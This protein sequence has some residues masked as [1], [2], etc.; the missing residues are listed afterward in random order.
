MLKEFTLHQL[1]V[2]ESVVRHGNFTRAAEE[3]MLT[4][5]TVSLQVKQ[6]TRAVGLP[7]FEQLGKRLYLTDAGQAVYET[8]QNLSEQ[9]GD[10]EI[11]LSEIKGVAQGRLRLAMPTAIKAFVPRML[12]SFL[13]SFPGVDISV[14]LTNYRY[15]IERLSH[16]EDD[17]YIMSQPPL[18]LPVKTLPLFDNP[19]VVVAPSQHPLA[20]QQHIPLSR[21]NG[22]AFIVREPGSRTRQIVQEFLQ[23]KEVQVNT[24][25]EVG[26]NEAVVEAVATGL[27]ISIL[28]R[29]ALPADLTNHLTILDVEGF[30]LQQSWY[31]VSSTRKLSVIA[32]TFL[33]KLQGEVSQQFVLPHP[34][35]N[36][37]SN[38][39][40]IQQP[41]A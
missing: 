41:A 38:G 28:S 24:R 15:L 17:L 18:G 7:L 23:S 1:K 39:L 11:K 40:V 8:C 12:N 13:D 33:E 26:G 25:L 29:Y 6:L 21:L 14:E 34:S 19:L 32:S 3:L 16:Q 10:F 20:G 30:P 31:V 4:Q 2:F 22:E 36:G 35:S 27:G 9:L 37:I 5:P